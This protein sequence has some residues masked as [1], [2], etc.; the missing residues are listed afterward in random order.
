MFGRNDTLPRYEI[1]RLLRELGTTR[2]EIE[3]SGGGDEGGI[4]NI[5]AYKKDVVLDVKLEEAYIPTVYCPSTKTWKPERAMTDQ[6]KLC[7]ALGKPIDDAYGSF[8]GEYHVN[9]TLVYDVLNE[10]IKMNKS[11]SVET[12]EES[13]ENF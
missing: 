9:G 3:F 5:V 10:T 2:V 11:E 6:E 13:E 4:D 12:W 1:F 8:A 7:Q